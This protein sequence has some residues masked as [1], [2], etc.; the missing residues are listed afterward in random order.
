MTESQ[1]PAHPVPLVPTAHSEGR[2][3]AFTAVP[4]LVHSYL[5]PMIC[6]VY[7]VTPSTFEDIISSALWGGSDPA[8]KTE[9]ASRPSQ[10][11]SNNPCS[12][13]AKGRAQAFLFPQIT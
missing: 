6:S 13:P 10:G 9:D 8:M 7:T 12:L 3:L 11:H 1:S 2:K 5:L 4:Y